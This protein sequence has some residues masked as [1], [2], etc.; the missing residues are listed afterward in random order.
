[1]IWSLAQGSSG[2]AVGVD[3]PGNRLVSCEILQNDQWVPIDPGKNYRI[4]INSFMYQQSGDG[5]FWFKQFGTRPL[6]TMS[7]LYSVLVE[8]A[9]RQEILDPI[10][11]DGRL[12]IRGKPVN[13]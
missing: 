8:N 1:M 10:P 11:K 7:T 12:V 4:A 3:R 5:Y 2:N 13:E 6:N 9:S